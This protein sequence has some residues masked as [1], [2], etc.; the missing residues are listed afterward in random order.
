MNINEL[1]LTSHAIETGSHMHVIDWSVDDCVTSET[2]GHTHTFNKHKGVTSESEGH[3]HTC[4]PV[5]CRSEFI[6]VEELKEFYNM[7][8]ID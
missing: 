4:P 5:M 1:V 8:V 6:S 3:R 2:N 7:Q